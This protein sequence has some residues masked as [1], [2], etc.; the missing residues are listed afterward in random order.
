MNT[1][2]APLPV[3]FFIEIFYLISSS[4]AAK[5]TPPL[6]KPIEKPPAGQM[7]ESGHIQERNDADLIRKNFPDRN[8]NHLN[9]SV[10][11]LPEVNINIPRAHPSNPAGVSPAKSAG[12]NPNPL[13][14]GAGY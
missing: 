5:S 1:I 3:A 13:F 2:I 12:V 7:S 6:G 14:S 9:N 10:T 8:E 4:A 11:S